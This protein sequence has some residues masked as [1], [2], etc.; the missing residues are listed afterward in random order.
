MP[1]GAVEKPA[2][3]AIGC[4]F[5]ITKILYFELHTRTQKQTWSEDRESLYLLDDVD[6]NIVCRPD[7]NAARCRI[8]R[9]YQRR[10]QQQLAIFHLQFVSKMAYASH[11]GGYATTILT[12]EQQKI[13]RTDTNF[14]LEAVSIQNHFHFAVLS[15]RRRW[16]RRRQR[17]WWWQWQW[18]RRQRHHATT[19]NKIAEKY[20]Y[21]RFSVSI[22]RIL[23]YYSTH[24]VEH[25]C[26][27]CRCCC[28]CWCACHEFS[29]SVSSFLRT[30]THTCSRAHSAIRV[31]T[32]E[33]IHTQTNRALGLGA[34]HMFQPRFI[35]HATHTH[36]HT[37]SVRRKEGTVVC[38]MLRTHRVR[39]S[40]ANVEKYL[41]CRQFSSATRKF[42]TKKKNS[43]SFVR[44]SIL[45][46]TERVPSV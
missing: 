40:E 43:S 19:R 36:S 8:E 29:T 1:L 39:L 33:K 32:I 14:Y 2:T 3:N 10:Q 20:L 22:V 26:W 27:S 44:R 12:A 30:H 23:R 25:C 45:W 7:L 17:W 46:H 28:D 42:D 24:W 5:T 9:K 38:G 15:V 16:W 34:V 35:L 4:D 6:L 37:E 21:R 31:A 41:L 18:R 13:T 11:G